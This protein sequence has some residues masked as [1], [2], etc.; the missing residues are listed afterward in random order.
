M[1]LGDLPV[2]IVV[3]VLID[4]S[5]AAQARAFPGMKDFAVDMAVSRIFLGLAHALNKAMREV[6]PDA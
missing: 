4:E 1:K 6:T 5:K 3:D 2:A